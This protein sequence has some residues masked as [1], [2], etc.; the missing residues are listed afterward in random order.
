MEILLTLSN[1][2]SAATEETLHPHSKDTPPGHKLEPGVISPLRELFF[3]P[4]S[5]SLKILQLELRV[6][7]RLDVDRSDRAVTFPDLFDAPHAGIDV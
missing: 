7:L 4:F 5:L 6:L 3:Q 1:P 2:I